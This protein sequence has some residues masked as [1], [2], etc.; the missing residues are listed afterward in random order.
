MNTG[1]SDESAQTAADAGAF[2]QKAA[3]VGDGSSS[4]IRRVGA[5]ASAVSVGARLLPAGL[6]FLRRYPIAATLV[7]AGIALAVYSLRGR[8]TDEEY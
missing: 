2:V 8:T 5:A 7:V 3:R 6:R 1:A 4:V